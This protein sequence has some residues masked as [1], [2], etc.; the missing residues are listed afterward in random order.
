VTI[1]YKEV[2]LTPVG[3][4]HHFY[5]WCCE[6]LRDGLNYGVGEELAH[7]HISALVEHAESMGLVLNEPAPKSYDLL[8]VANAMW[9]LIGALKEAE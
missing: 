1:K 9:K 2:K 4:A 8:G 6:E 5:W 7:K 3:E